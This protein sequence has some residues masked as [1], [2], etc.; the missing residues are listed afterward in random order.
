[1]LEHNKCNNT[2]D[3]DLF[4]GIKWACQ[5]PSARKSDEREYVVYVEDGNNVGQ[6]G[7]FH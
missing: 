2:L 7:N 1:M 5:K 4:V 3:Q 6:T